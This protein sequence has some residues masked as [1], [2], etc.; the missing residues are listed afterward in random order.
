VLD[1]RVIVAMGTM[2]H[3]LQ[4]RIFV[5]LDVRLAKSASCMDGRGRIFVA[6]AFLDDVVMH[7]VIDA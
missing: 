7:A 5:A 1:I 2:V 3:E 4:F 6:Q